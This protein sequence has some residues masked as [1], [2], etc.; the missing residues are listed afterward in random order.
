[1]LQIKKNLLVEEYNKNLVEFLIVLIRT[2]GVSSINYDLC[3]YHH[4][5]H[6]NLKLVQVQ[7]KLT[8]NLKKYLIF[9]FSQQLLL[10]EVIQTKKSSNASQKSTIVRT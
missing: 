9:T 3:K 10:S 8:E 1:M 2:A 6:L 4:L 7:M 5:D